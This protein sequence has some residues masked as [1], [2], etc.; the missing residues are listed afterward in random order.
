MLC[1][2][3]WFGELLLTVG[4]SPTQPFEYTYR[5]VYS[6]GKPL[7][8]TLVVHTTNANEHSENRCLMASN[9]RVIEHCGQLISAIYARNHP[10]DL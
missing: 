8:A 6:A 5:L 1:S 10:E 4:H 9:N 2:A 7:H 3:W